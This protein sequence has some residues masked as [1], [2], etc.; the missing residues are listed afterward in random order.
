MDYT[1]N[2][3]IKSDI[4]S[5]A[6]NEHI[7]WYHVLEFLFFKALNCIGVQE[8]EVAWFKASAMV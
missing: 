2:Y 6:D 8:I 4:V 7:V 1:D 3:L 5:Y